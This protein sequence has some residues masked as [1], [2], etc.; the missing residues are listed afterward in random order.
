[1]T[2]EEDDDTGIEKFPPAVVPALRMMLE[3]K[4]R[5]ANAHADVADAEAT[6]SD[7]SG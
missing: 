3:A 5:L 2:K 7:Q 1:M 4:A 6:G